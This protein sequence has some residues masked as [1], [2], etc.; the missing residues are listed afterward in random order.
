MDVEM[1]EGSGVTVPRKPGEW[2]AALYAELRR[3]AGRQLQ[4]NPAGAVSPTTLVHELY[5]S[6][7][8]GRVTE[9]PDR[10]RFMAYA[11]RA[12]RGLIVDFARHRQALKRGAG[13][14]ITR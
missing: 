13:F 12:M 6:F 3:L 4:R 11:G 10:E 14:E 7:T 9:F 5:V 2:F 8:N 1:N